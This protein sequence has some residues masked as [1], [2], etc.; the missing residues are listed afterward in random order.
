M[1]WMLWKWQD[2]GIEIVI[3]LNETWCEHEIYREWYPA[4]Y[5]YD[6][7]DRKIIAV[8]SLFEKKWAIH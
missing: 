2:I 8:I 6:G 4:G 3:E 1:G 7:W 5:A